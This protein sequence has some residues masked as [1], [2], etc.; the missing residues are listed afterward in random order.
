MKRLFASADNYLKNSDW[1][2]LALIKFCLFSIGL[3][4][5]MQ[6]PKRRK[7]P[8]ALAAFLLFVG[9]YFPL[10]YKYFWILGQ[11]EE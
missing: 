5:G 9:T 11:T 4:V 1:R 2:D 3:L 10:M 7:E 6:I 8:A